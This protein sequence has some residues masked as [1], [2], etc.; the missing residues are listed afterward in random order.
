MSGIM[1]DVKAAILLQS[2][3][4]NMFCNNAEANWLRYE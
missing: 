3:R 4:S 2:L 1:F